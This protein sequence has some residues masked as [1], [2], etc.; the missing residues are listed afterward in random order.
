M[1]QDKLDDGSTDI[2]LYDPESVGVQMWD[3]VKDEKLCSIIKK[4]CDDL[5]C[6]WRLTDAMQKRKAVK[7]MCLKWHPDKNPSPL[8][9]EAFQFLQH[10]V[11][12]LD[13]EDSKDK[14]DY[15]RSDTRTP[16]WDN[17][18]QEFNKLVNK[19]KDCLKS[20]KESLH[21][22]KPCLFDDGM[23]R[24]SHKVR[25]DSR[26]AEIWFRQAEH[27]LKALHVLFDSSSKELHAH[28]CFMA[29]QV[30]EKALKAGMYQKHGLPSENLEHHKLVGLAKKLEADNS[31][32]HSL[33][34][35]AALL[36]NDRYVNYYLDTRY[37]NRLDAVPSDNF[38]G[39]QA[40]QAKDA[41]EKIVK[42]IE[43][44]IRRHH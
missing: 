3:T 34:D 41:A 18:F 44:M 19:W 21:E 32:A 23:R 24:A 15:N 9:T 1:K 10:Q 43:Q 7:S 33:E 22:N 20:E 31:T 8:A 29:H 26:K 14:E 36:M 17:N 35:M 25:S 6:I 39:E 28:V 30:A 27:D 40:S 11:K 38:T 5:K 37:P 13:Q 12:Q 42:I 16:D 2:V 4:I